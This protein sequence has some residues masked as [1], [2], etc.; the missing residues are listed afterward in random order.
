VADSSGNPAA[1]VTRTVNVVD[2][3]KPVI[4][5]LGS[6][7]VD[8]DAGSAYSDAGATA[9]DN[10]DGDLTG[11]IAAV[12]S[13]E[14][15]VVGSYFVTYSVSD[16]SGNAADTV[17]RT[18]NV[19]ATPTPTPEPTVTPTPEPTPTPG[20]TVTPTPEPTTVVVPVNDTSINVTGNNT[21]VL[22]NGS[23]P[24]S[25][26]SFSGNLSEAPQLN[27][28]GVTSNA[29]GTPTA[30]LANQLNVT[31]SSTYL[32]GD[33]SVQF[34]AGIVISGPAGW[35]GTMDLPFVESVT[36]ATANASPGA[37]ST[38]TLGVISIGLAS[39][40]LTFDKA[41]RIVFPGL[42]GYYAGFVR[43][44]VFTQITDACA[45]DS[46]AAGD[47]LPAGGDCLIS[48][49][50]DLVIWTKHFTT[51]LTYGQTYPAAEHSRGDF[52]VPYTPAGGGVV[53]GPVTTPNPPNRPATPAVP[54]VVSVPTPVTTP[55]GP[56]ATMPPAANRG[57]AA[58]AAGAAAD[59]PGAGT[60]LAAAKAQDSF[61]SVTGMLIGS[62]A[63]VPN[64]LVLV[65][66]SAAL[67][68]AYLFATRGRKKP[69]PK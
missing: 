58:P 45:N 51:F 16:T 63:G 12:N 27:L 24:A 61:S 41:V 14:T 7:P 5:L 10:Y 25:T 20:P 40:A 55:R 38:T 64:L 33:M 21:V 46:Q 65:L 67:G 52:V 54:P 60:G 17:T 68:W 47:A 37:T 11:S 56:P 39:D 18:V 19:V 43:N 4:T 36:T 44:G 62:T 28:S 23:S 1:Q 3:T 48:A 32:S 42:A 26:V 31:Q 69:H 2:T 15:S 13:V 59:A 9:L 50:P 8:V 57:A 35:D 66:L 29:S 34:P 53:S 49:G 6:N 22:I 30:T